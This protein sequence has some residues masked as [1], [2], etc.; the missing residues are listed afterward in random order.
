MKQ[1]RSR[2]ISL[3]GAI[4]KSP[5]LLSHHSIFA[6]EI[7]S[8]I[9]IVVA[10]KAIAKRLPLLFAYAFKSVKERQLL[11]LYGKQYRKEA[12]NPSI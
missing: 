8:F 7:T 12:K 9:A 3:Q 10:L 2:V 11:R 4:E 1:R 5:K 6:S